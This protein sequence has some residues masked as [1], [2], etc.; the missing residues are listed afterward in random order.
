MIELAK[1]AHTP[2]MEKEAIEFMALAP[3]ANCVDMTV[4]LGGHA[5]SILTV[6]SPDGRLLGFDRDSET[7][8]LTV[9]ISEAL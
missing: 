7:L 5:E 1:T 3:G 2:V 9:F 8:A 4:G 6:T